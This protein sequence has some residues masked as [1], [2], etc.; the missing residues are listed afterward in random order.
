MHERRAGRIW[1]DNKGYH[2]QYDSEYLAAGG[3]PVSLTM[4]LQ[5]MSYTERSTLHPVFDNLIPEGWL[6]DI[7]VRNWKLNPADRLGL[8]L[9]VC[10]ECI[11]AIQVMSDEEQIDDNA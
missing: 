5:E 9:T 8:L 11:G 7:A 6:L 4:P 10:H 2:F 1:R 3:P